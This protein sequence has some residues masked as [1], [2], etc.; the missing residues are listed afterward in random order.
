MFLAGNNMIR[1]ECYSDKPRRD[2][3]RISMATVDTATKAALKAK[4]PKTIFKFPMLAGLS[5]NS[6]FMFASNGSENKAENGLVTPNH[7]AFAI[8]EG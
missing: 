3:S 5:S 1:G 8:C 6:C 2:F 7:S 4:Y